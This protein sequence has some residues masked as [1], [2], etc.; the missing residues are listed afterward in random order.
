MKRLAWYLPSPFI[1]T[2][3]IYQKMKSEIST[4]ADEYQITDYKIK[5]TGHGSIKHLLLFL[6]EKDA[7]F[8]L[9][10]KP[11]SVPLPDLVEDHANN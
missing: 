11:S 6:S 7:T 8:F 5:V 3:H 10:S 2:D 1:A 4:W 9:I